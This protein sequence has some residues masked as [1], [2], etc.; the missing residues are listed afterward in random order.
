MPGGP[1]MVLALTEHDSLLALLLGLQVC[2]ISVWVE[3][4]E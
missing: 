3:G 1:P 2:A 4:G